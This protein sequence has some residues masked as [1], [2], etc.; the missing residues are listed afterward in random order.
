MTSL[1]SGTVDSVLGLL[2]EKQSKSELPAGKAA[3]GSDVSSTTAS[4]SAQKKQ[5]TKTKKAPE[6]VEPEP[7]VVEETVEGEPF[8]TWDEIEFLM[9]DMKLTREEAAQVLTDIV[10]PDP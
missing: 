9:R 10:G 8:Y 6:P 5:K 4:S 3:G 2:R 1:P 7:K